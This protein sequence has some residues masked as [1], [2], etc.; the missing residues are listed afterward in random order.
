MGVATPIESL[1]ITTILLAHC[2]LPKHFHPVLLQPP[3]QGLWTG[4]LQVARFRLP[5]G[6]SHTLSNAPT[7]RE[8]SLYNMIVALPLRYDPLKDVDPESWLALDELERLNYVLD[9]HQRQR[10][11]LP[12]QKIHATMH[13]VVENQLA[14][15][16][17]FPAKSVLARLMSE[18]LD[19][20]DAIHAIGSVLAGQIFDALK[21]KDPT[22]DLNAEYQQKLK[23][24][25]AQSW[26]KRV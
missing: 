11:R 6:L 21:H 13:V 4:I 14:L 10:I 12:N 25:T 15:G 3:N 16:D 8:K 24:L 2:P 1:L 7:V 20:H 26:L 9:Y 5:G 23:A 22:R 18:G 19:R 17:S